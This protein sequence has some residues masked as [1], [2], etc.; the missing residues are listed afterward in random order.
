MY[1]VRDDDGALSNEAEVAISIVQNPFP[2]QNAR[3]HLDVNDDG[4]VSPLD[5]L[6]VIND[7]NYRG[8]R[9]LP[10][11]PVPPLLPPPF[12]DTS[13]NNRVEPLDAVLVI[14]YLSVGGGGEGE[15]AGE[16]VGAAREPAMWY[17]GPTVTTG[18]D[19]LAARSSAQLAEQTPAAESSGTDDW[20]LRVG[21]APAGATLAALE[22][23][24]LDDVLDSIA[25]DVEEARDGDLAE[26]FA[27][28]DLL[29]GRRFS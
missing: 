2:W 16:S 14:N 20:K 11:P 28:G 25:D 12:L 10:N 23:D 8:S 27:I 13:G 19:R 5:A 6:L 22:G 29:K 18:F 24:E 7:L 4:I 17:A 9:D 21:E 3:M 15:A 1:T 26:D